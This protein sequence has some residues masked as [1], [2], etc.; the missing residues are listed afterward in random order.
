MLEADQATVDAA[1]DRAEVVEVG[2]RIEPVAIPV[3]HRGLDRV[4]FGHPVRIG[5]HVRTAPLR[6][7]AVIVLAG[8]LDQSATTIPIAVAAGLRAVAHAAGVDAVGDLLGL[9]RVGLRLGV[10][11]VI[12]AEDLAQAF[13]GVVEVLL[14]QAQA[15]GFVHQ[16]REKVRDAQLGVDAM[17]RHC[18]IE[19]IEVTIGMRCR[20][21]HPGE[22]FA[23]NQHGILPGR[24]S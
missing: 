12:P 3:V 6:E 21:P 8:E 22:Q 9:A 10:A 15:A 2:E 13:G 7:A 23:R 16:L 17:H 1:R 5:H 18:R 14:R 11:A 24:G 19:R 4:P 20:G